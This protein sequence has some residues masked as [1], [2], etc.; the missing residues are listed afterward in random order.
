MRPEPPAKL[1][2]RTFIRRA[3]VIGGTGLVLAGSPALLA[4]CGG[5][6]TTTTAEELSLSSDLGGTQLV[7]LFNYT[8]NYLVTGA[9]Q[10][11]PFTIATPEGPP[12]ES[13]PDTLTVRLRNGDRIGDPVVLTRHQDGTPIGYYPL[14]T[15]FDTVGT[16][17]IITDLDGRE[18]SQS[19]AVQT[20][21]SVPLIQP[22]QPMPSVLTP[23]VDD[24][25]GVTPICTNVPPCPLH[26][27]TLADALALRTPVALLIGTPQFCQTGVCGPVLDLLLELKPEFPSVEFLHAEVYNN[28]NSGGD[29]AAAGLA[30]VVNSYGLSFE[31]SLFIANPN[32]T[33]ATRL[34]N[35]FDRT[36]MRRALAS[37]SA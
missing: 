24:G 35:I 9:P 2:R 8:G 13:G 33:V 34:D 23:T 18:V 31:P 17:S 28:P 27:Q 7:G 3:G 37:V 4:A 10:R 32:G 19:F 30:P 6:S 25:R 22:G 12:A 15:T 16:W 29:P 11:L 36:E 20:P 1:D 14:I 26:T 21:A 5:S